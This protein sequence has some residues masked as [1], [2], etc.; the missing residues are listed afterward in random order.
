MDYT[1]SDAYVTHVGTGYRLH[2]ATAA[3][4]TRVTADDLNRLHWELMEL[5]VAAG[6]AP[7]PFDADVPATYQQVRISVQT[8]ATTIANA[9]VAAAMATVTPALVPVG[10]VIMGYFPAAPAGY[11]HGLGQLVARS[12]YPALWAYVQAQSLAVDD[13][14]WLAGQTGLFSTGDGATTLRLPYL[15][16]E[17]VRLA[18]MGRGLDTGRALGSVQ[19]GSVGPHT[20]AISGARTYS[21]SLDNITATALAP[22]EGTFGTPATVATD[23]NSGTETR[24]RNVALTGCI[25]Y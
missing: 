20:H 18:D 5:L 4:T 7:Q 2:Q 14:S 17:F 19:F 21:I 16:G 25:K 8:L 11:V 23:S 15:A 3:L 1:T 6:I 10:T 13:A 9:A 12:A 22:N 24:P